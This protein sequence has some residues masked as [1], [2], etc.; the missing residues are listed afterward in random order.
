MTMN[1][2]DHVLAAEYVL[3]TLDA[4]E[5]HEAER[6]IATSPEFAALVQG[7]ERR[8]GPLHDRLP[9]VEPPAGLFKRIEER[10]GATAQSPQTVALTS[11]S[12]AREPARR[13]AA[14]ADAGRQLRQW[15]TFGTAMAALAAG[16]AAFMVTSLWRPDVL[17]ES[18]RPKPRVVMVTN[19]IIRTAEAPS[20]YVAIMQKDPDSPGFI[21]TVD[22]EKRTLTARRVAAED[23]TNKSY[24]LWLVSKDFPAPRSL[25]LIGEQDFTTSSALA[26]YPPSTISDATFAVSLEPQGGSPTGTATGPVLWTGKLVETVPPGQTP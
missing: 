14:V 18:L 9:P 21:L 7:W 3:G 5:R 6:R 25:G 16:L 13:S 17:P 12:A 23:L 4:A 1:D 19:T 10:L 24:E 2:E 26:N 20:R 15:R 8:L 22:L 11:R